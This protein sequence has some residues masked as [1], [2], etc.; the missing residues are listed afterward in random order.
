LVT[1]APVDAVPDGPP[2]AISGPVGEPTWISVAETPEG[3][4]NVKVTIPKPLELVTGFGLAEKTLGFVAKT[5]G[6]GCSRNEF[7]IW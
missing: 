2:V 4:L 3:A 7:T 1:H 5:G 6:M